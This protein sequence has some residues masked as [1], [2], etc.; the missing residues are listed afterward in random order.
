VTLT[1]PETASR[2]AAIL[3]EVERA[4]V[5]KRDVLERVLL[6]IL[7][8]GHV[9]LDDVP[10]VAKTLTA[11]SLA[12]ATGLTFSRVQFTPDLLP[13]DVTGAVVLDPS[14]GSF[15]FRPGPVF[16]GFVLAD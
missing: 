8:A 16:A 4:V 7:G 3:D 10:G 1:I 6:G 15:A 14:S 12:V 2:A 11:R 13:A 5:G 9:L